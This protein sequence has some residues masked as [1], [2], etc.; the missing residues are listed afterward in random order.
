VTRGALAR[1]ALALLVIALPAALAAQRT[2]RV[3]L[4]VGAGTVPHDRGSLGR[5]RVAGVTAAAGL[6]M[7]V[8][9]RAYVEATAQAQGALD[10]NE[11]LALE[12]VPGPNGGFTTRT[13]TTGGDAGTGIAVLARVGAEALG[14]GR[15]PT[16]RAAAGIGTMRVARG[17]VTTVTAGLS[18]PGRRMRLTLDADGW[19]YRVRAVETTWPSQRSGFYETQSRSVRVSLR[20]TFVRLGVEL[21]TGR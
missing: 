20:S 14:G 11:S 5:D 4:S 8:W 10:F 3:L 12:V 6:R 2:P 9:R 16:L 19:W 13:V 7:P 21:P 1:G 17:P 18:S 15:R